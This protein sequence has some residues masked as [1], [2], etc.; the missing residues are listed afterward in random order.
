MKKIKLYPYGFLF[1]ENTLTNIPGNF[2]NIDLNDGYYFYYDPTV[3]MEYIHTSDAFIIVHGHFTYVNPDN[4]VDNKQL[5]EL[6]FDSFFN[7][8]TN[9]L[10]F[11]YYLVI[12]YVIF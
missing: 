11:L 8:Y 6:L 9:F 4:L 10:N 2:V 5:V 7:Y 3:D 12:I 1:S